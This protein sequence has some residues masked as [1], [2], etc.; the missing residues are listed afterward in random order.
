MVADKEEDPEGVADKE[1]DPEGVA[2]LLQVTEPLK[3]V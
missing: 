3:L 1:E 2:V